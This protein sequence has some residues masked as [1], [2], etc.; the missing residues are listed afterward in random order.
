MSGDREGRVKDLAIGPGS[1]ERAFVE[2]IRWRR[3]G[4]GFILFNNCITAG[5]LLYCYSMNLERE[6]NCAPG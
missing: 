1:R 6:G 3:G 4:I 2:I 5:H